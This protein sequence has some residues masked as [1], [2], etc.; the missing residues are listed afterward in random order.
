MV[1][2]LDVEDVGIWDLRGD[3]LAFLKE[4]S[5]VRY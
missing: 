2:I 5:K 3:A 4:A 1:S